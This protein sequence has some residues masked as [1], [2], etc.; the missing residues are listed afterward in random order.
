MNSEIKTPEWVKESIIIGLNRPNTITVRSL[1]KRRLLAVVDRI[2]R[3]M[4]GK[5]Y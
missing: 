1:V 5:I 3:R 2:Y 4:Y